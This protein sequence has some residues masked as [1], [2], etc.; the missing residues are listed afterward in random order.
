MVPFGHLLEI[1]V[2]LKS[3]Q[4]EAENFGQVVD[5]GGLLSSHWALVGFISSH[6]VTKGVFPRLVEILL[7]LDVQ[8]H[9]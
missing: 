4:L 7:G 6:L 3:V 9:V 8:H 5:P 1:P 2:V